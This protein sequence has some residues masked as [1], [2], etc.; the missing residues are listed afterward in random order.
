MFYCHILQTVTVE[1]QVTSPSSMAE[2]DLKSSS[3]SCKRM[4]T[5]IQKSAPKSIKSVIKSIQH[6][7]L[8][9]LFPLTSHFLLDF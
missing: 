9:C 8:H 6:L 7:N 5:E 3:F 2:F 4:P 1:K